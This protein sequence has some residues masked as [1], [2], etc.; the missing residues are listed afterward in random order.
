MR[1]SIRFYI[2]IAFSLWCISVQSSLVHAQ[3]SWASTYTLFNKAANLN[4]GIQTI[5]GGFIF[6]GN[7]D[8]SGSYDLW[9]LK[10]DPF[11]IIVW[12]KTYGGDLDDYG[13]S[14]EQTN[15][16]GF[17]VSGQTFSFGTGS[18]DAW[19]LRLDKVGN[20]EWQKTIGQSQ[21]D[22]ALSVKQTSDGF[23]VAGGTYPS[24]LPPLDFWV[25]KL[26]HSGN[27]VWQKSYGG[28]GD[29]IA[30]SVNVTSDD[31]FIVSGYTDSFGAGF[32]DLWVLKLDSTGNVQW[33]KSYGTSKD[34]FPTRGTQQT[35]DGGF[36]IAATTTDRANPNPTGDIIVL[37]LDS[38]G[39][40]QW[41]KSYG[42]SAADGANSIE[43]T[44]DGG[45]IVGGETAAV[46]TGAF[47]LLRLDSAGN[48]TWQKAYQGNNSE[49]LQTLN[50]TSDGGFIA[51]GTDPK[52]PTSVGT[53]MIRV[54]D[55]GEIDPTC[56]FVTDTIALAANSTFI[57][58]PTTASVVDTSLIPSS[59]AAMVNTGA[60][61]YSQQCANTC[62]FCDD[63]GDG[64]LA[65]DW[66]YLKPTWSESGG[67]LIGS[68]IKKKAETIASPA[69]VGCD[70]CSVQATMKS[71]G[72]IGN[73]ISLLTH[74]LDK[75]N[76]V[77]VIL[78]E[79]ADKVVLKQRLNGRIV[80][81]AKSS[82]KIDP[83]TSY[84]V[85]L[86]YDGFVLRLGINGVRILSLTPVGNLVSA[87]VGF[88]T[89]NTDAFFGDIRVD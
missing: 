26:D 1:D 76:N 44:T 63:F 85:H 83:N 27:V 17:I 89:V 9:L 19:I 78:N 67:D 2:I 56:T 21:T 61:Q 84:D 62:I 43:Q 25:I 30:Y 52:R 11:G 4:A 86:N 20:I 53:F 54:A 32:Y 39:Q 68:P 88:K 29:E 38:T 69:F 40:I 24:S 23:I 55:N 71:S 13:F 45:Y 82:L 14:V 15:D 74:Y 75:R 35:T 57:E 48:I 47:W 36:A 87:T 77:E 50:Q 81:K 16:E 22:F 46:G 41:Q 60:A 79:E 42:S 49:V 10:L 28:T 51:S 31:G 58:L 6:T 7:M 65:T 59:T 3:N 8:V 73:R 70:V 72:G 33:Q 34:E 18:N 12:Q 64:V 80:S 37:K 66:T 5:D